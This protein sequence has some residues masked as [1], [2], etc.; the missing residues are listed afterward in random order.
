MLVAGT[1]Y[2]SRVSTH[3]FWSV[4]K[5]N[6]VISFSKVELRREV[7]MSKILKPIG[8]KVLSQTAPDYMA[9]SSLLFIARISLRDKLDGVSNFTEPRQTK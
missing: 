2:F 4:T 8:T 6:R 9:W 1:P 3:T 5:G 7:S